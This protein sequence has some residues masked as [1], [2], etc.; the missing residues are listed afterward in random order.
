[1]D[2]INEKVILA[3][4]LTGAD[5]EKFNDLL[6]KQNILPCRVIKKNMG[7]VTIREVLRDVKKT[8]GNSELP[9]EKLLIF[10]N[11]A[12]KELYELI[13]DIRQIKSSDTILAAVTP[14]SINWT[15]SYLMHHLIA[16]REAYKKSK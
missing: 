9:N 2:L 12:D 16:E 1:M 6:V 10:S 8:E 4:G 11:F 13:D 7:N 3:Y 5:E 14:T 15:V